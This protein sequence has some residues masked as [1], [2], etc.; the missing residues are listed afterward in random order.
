MMEKPTIHMTQYLKPPYTRA[1]LEG[2][3]VS[4]I[5]VDNGF[6]MNVLLMKSLWK[7]GKTKYDLI[8]INMTLVSLNRDELQMVKVLPIEITIGTK[9]ALAA[10]F[11]LPQQLNVMPF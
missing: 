3:P 1:H 6:V 7:V 2:V 11:S 9:S 4:R 8:L 5:L 10:F